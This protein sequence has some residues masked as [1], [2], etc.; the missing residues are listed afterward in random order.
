MAGYIESKTQ[1]GVSPGGQSPHY[2]AS[3]WSGTD[4]CMSCWPNEQQFPDNKGMGSWT[5]M[6]TRLNLTERTSERSRS[7]YSTNGL[8]GLNEEAGMM[9]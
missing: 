2:Q 3:V 1:E 5:S 6:K 7:A 4:A 9:E 8:N